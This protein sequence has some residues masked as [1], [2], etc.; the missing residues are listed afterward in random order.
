MRFR[1]RRET[2]DWL[3]PT[4]LVATIEA[5]IDDGEQVL[6]EDLEVGVRA[7]VDGEGRP[8]LP[9]FSGER[10]LVAWIPEG[11]HFIGLHGRDLLHL[12]LNGEWDHVVVDPAGPNSR[13]LS[14]AGASAQLDEAT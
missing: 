6:A 9:V 4:F 12:F 8:F 7:S 11:S 14:R 5:A 10:E 2:Y 3:E 1:K 13:G